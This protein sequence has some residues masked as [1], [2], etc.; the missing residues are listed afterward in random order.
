MCDIIRY[1]GCHSLLLHMCDKEMQQVYVVVIACYY[2]C[3]TRKCSRYMC[4]IIRYMCDGNS[5]YQVYV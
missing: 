3:V 4:D 1:I 2:I 5:N